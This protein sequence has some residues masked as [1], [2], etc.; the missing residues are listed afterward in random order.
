MPLP[1]KAPANFI[2]DEYF[3]EE[4]QNRRLGSVEGD[5]LEEFCMG[6]KVY[7]EKSLGKILLYKQERMQL[8]DVRKWWETGRFEEWD[9][10]GPGDCY[11]AEHLARLLGECIYLLEFSSS[12]CGSMGL[13]CACSQHA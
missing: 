4:K 13:I 11:G 2:I 1:S 8:A 3:N 5:I 9:G 12:F 7:F 6:L 10:K